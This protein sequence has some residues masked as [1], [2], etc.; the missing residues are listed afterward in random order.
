MRSDRK[1]G[2]GDPTGWAAT[3]AAGLVTG[4]LA[5]YLVWRLSVAYYES[6]LTE[7]LRGRRIGSGGLEEL[8]AT[9]GN[10]ALGAVLGAGL[11]AWGIGRLLGYRRPEVS[12]V[13]FALLMVVLAPALAGIGAV[14]LP[15]NIGIGAGAVFAFVT[16][17]ALAGIVARMVAEK[18]AARDAPT[19]DAPRPGPPP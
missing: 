14:L 1:G 9:I 7:G 10:T 17:A 3:A 13:L 2:A 4:V 12:G 19:R 6:R 11:G 18:A 16:A 15:I 5:G 8:G